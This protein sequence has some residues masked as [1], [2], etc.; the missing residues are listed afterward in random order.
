LVDLNR[1]DQEELLLHTQVIACHVPP[2]YGRPGIGG[3]S[4]LY[5]RARQFDNRTRWQGQLLM[6]CRGEPCPEPSTYFSPEPQVHP[7]AIQ[8]LPDQHFFVVESNAFN[9]GVSATLTHL[10][11]WRWRSKLPEYLQRISLDTWCG[12]S[13]DY[14]T[15]E[16]GEDILS[17]DWEITP[18]GHILIPSGEET[19]R[20]E[21]EPTTLYVCNGE[22]FI[23]QE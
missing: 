11:L 5:L 22:N 12:R 10:D 16:Q 21:A 7:F 17:L 8:S 23:E 2:L 4:I 20:C 3:V 19:E 18:E 1:D 6:P 9:Y 13:G 15:N 14:E